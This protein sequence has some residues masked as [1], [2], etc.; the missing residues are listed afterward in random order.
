MLIIV[1][2]VKEIYII[3]CIKDHKANNPDLFL[4]KIKSNINENEKPSDKSIKCLTCGDT[5]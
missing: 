5:I 1:K 4:S 3:K 2:I